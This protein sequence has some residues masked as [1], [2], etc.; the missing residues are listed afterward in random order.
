[1]DWRDPGSGCAMNISPSILTSVFKSLG[2]DPAQF[3]A[4]WTGFIGQIARFDALLQEQTSA[5]KAM[6]A[7]QE[8]DTDY[9]AG[10]VDTI[11]Y[12]LEALRIKIDPDYVAETP[13]GDAIIAKMHDP[14]IPLE[15]IN[16]EA[17][18][19]NQ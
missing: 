17:Q 1:M 10:K 4:T 12:Q 6:I 13:I 16:G 3:Q 14:H 15:A 2:I 18:G 7:A 19:T 5:I 11:S 9:I 8:H